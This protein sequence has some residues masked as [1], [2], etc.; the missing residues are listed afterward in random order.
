MLEI[1]VLV[2]AL[3]EKSP[4]IISTTLNYYLE[5]RKGGSDCFFPGTASDKRRRHA[6]IYYTER[7]EIL[8]RV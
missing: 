2:M 5:P 3:V 1:L 4:L 7:V 8:K 6:E